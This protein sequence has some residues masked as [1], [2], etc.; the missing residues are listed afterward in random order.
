MKTIISI[1]RPII[2]VNYLLIIGCFSLT[3]FDFKCNDQKIASSKGIDYVIN[4]E[5]FNNAPQE[6]KDDGYGHYAEGGNKV[7]A[8]YNI[9]AIT[10]LSFALLG[11]FYILYFYYSIV[12]IFVGIV[13]FF[14]IIGLYYDISNK[15][16]ENENFKVLNIEL[17]LGYILSLIGFILAII[18]TTIL[19][20]VLKNEKT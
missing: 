3:F 9:W 15:I 7:Y 12:N 10:A 11:F 20:R 4:K 17:G 8:G 2:S 16:N 19:Y 1:L 6:R 18:L 13:G 14:S 5:L